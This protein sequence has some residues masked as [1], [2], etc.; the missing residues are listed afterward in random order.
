MDIKGLFTKI[1][2]YIVT[3]LLGTITDTVVLWCLAH[4]VFGDSHFEQYIVSPCISFECAVFVNYLTAYFYVW[5][6]RIN[7][8]KSGVF[9]GH[10]WKYNLTCV[11]AFILK[12][13]ILNGVAVASKWDPVICN[14]IALCFSGVLNFVINEF[15]VFRTKEAKESKEGNLL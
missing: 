2:K 12:M 5:K 15:V 3:T 8:K 14:L 7:R 11:S 1:V 13:V 4:Y 9:F 10:F 6:D